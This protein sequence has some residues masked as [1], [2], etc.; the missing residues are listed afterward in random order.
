VG[1]CPT[2]SIQA[3]CPVWG[4]GFKSDSWPLPDQVLLMK[5]KPEG[6]SQ[7]AEVGIPIPFL[8]MGW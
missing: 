8:T 7:A 3:S 1:G 2:H 5:Q 4:W 6:L